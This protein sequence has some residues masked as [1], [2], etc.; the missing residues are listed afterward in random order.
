MPG[1]KKTAVVAISLLITDEKLNFFRI[2]TSPPKII[3]NPSIVSN[4]SNSFRKS[5]D[6]EALD[7]Q[8]PQLLDILEELGNVESA[9]EH[10]VNMKNLGHLRGHF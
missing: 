9:K 6:F 10:D 7:T 5:E 1:D 3:N 8:D 4:S 2:A